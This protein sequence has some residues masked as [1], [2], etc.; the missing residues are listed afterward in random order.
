MYPSQNATESLPAPGSAD[1]DHRLTLQKA[2]HDV[3][4][5]LG[6]LKSGDARKAVSRSWRHHVERPRVAARTPI[7]GHGGGANLTRPSSSANMGAFQ[8]RGRIQRGQPPEGARHR[9]RSRARTRVAA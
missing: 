5:D 2:D 7:S 4:R 9:P 8:P 1:L 6:V 3:P